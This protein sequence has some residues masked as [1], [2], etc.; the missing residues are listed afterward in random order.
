MNAITKTQAEA[1]KAGFAQIAPQIRAALPSHIPFERFERVVMMAV[2]KEPKLL[3]CDQRSLFL[4]CQKAAADGLLPD[5]REGVIVFRWNSKVG[6][7]FAVWQPMVA[8]L[9]KLARNSGEIASI[10]AH[11]VYEG[12]TFEYVMGDEEKIVHVRDLNAVDNR[13]PIAAYAIFTLKN[14]EK[15]REVMSAGQIEEVRNSNPKWEKG[16]WNGPF[17]TEMW[18]K[19]PIRRGFKRGPSSTDRDGDMRLQS[20]IERIDSEV[21][22]EGRAEEMKTEPLRTTSKLDALESVVDVDAD[23]AVIDAEPVEVPNDTPPLSE[24]DRLILDIEACETADQLAVIEGNAAIKAQVR[25]MS[26]EDRQRVKVAFDAVKHGM[27]GNK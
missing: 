12:E 18:R 8:G 16:P 27:E 26:A 7:N 17:A 2:Q 21:V 5:G 19:S 9:M 13:K 3:E 25:A 1:F 15:I 4:E 6:K 10:N 14:G 22:L 11:V 24:A 20:A 23:G